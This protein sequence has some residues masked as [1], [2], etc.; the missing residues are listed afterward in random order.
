MPH[1]ILKKPN[2]LYAVWSTIADNWLVDNLTLDQ[3][4][5]YDM[6]DRIKHAIKESREFFADGN[7][8][9]HIKKHDYN[10]NTLERLRK[11]NHGE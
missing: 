7:L 10:Y 5:Q 4:K 9:T 8:E 2:G 1:L 6:V 11:L 3:L